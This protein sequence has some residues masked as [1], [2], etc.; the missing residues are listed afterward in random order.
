MR[1][2]AWVLVGMLL[3]SGCS[4]LILRDKDSTGD[5]VGKVVTRVL[6]C[7]LTLCL[8]EA[9]IV[10]IKSEEEMQAWREQ[11]ARTPMDPATAAALLSMPLYPPM[12]LA[13]FPS[14][15]PPRTGM[16]MHQYNFSNGRSMTCFEGQFATNCF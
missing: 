11:M 5:T 13:P 9:A 1:Y 10:G 6:L 7:P 8:S 3:L 2:T 16:P 14:Y 12:P 4:G 15:Q